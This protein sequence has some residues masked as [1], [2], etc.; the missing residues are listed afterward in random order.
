MQMHGIKK[1]YIRRDGIYI[2]K[3]KQEVFSGNVMQ[4]CHLT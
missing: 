4:I 2:W 3:E 1:P